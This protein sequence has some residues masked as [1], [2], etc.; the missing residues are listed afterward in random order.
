M[1][2]YVTQVSRVLF[3]TDPMGTCCKENDCFDEYAAI[4]NDIVSRRQRGQPYQ[5][6]R[7]A[8]IMSRIQSAKLNGLEPH[9]YPRKMC[10]LSC[11]RTRPAR[12]TNSYLS[13]GNRA[14]D[15]SRRIMPVR[16]R[17]ADLMSKP[18]SAIERWIDSWTEI[19]QQVLSWHE[20]LNCLTVY[21]LK[22]AGITRP[23]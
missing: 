16:L 5:V 21:Y 17:I 4:A 14:T 6:E 18:T 19:A 1:T 15:Y 2:L 12:S 10:W 11:R 13:T 7:A 8:N 23:R 22:K 9:A 3:E 20:G